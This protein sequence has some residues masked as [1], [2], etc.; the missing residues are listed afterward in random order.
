V[1]C[2]QVRAADAALA[3]LRGQIAA[4]FEQLGAGGLTPAGLLAR[5]RGMGV[6][7]HCSPEQLVAALR[8]SLAPGCAAAACV[9][10]QLSPL[11]AC[12]WAPRQVCAMVTEPAL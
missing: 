9:S 10:A 4:A 6:E 7:V 12:T 8:G 11:R 1:A 5:L 2:G 3:G